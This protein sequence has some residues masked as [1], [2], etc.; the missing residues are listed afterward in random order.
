MSTSVR[1][2][3]PADPGPNAN[4]RKA[5][6]WSRGKKAT[7]FSGG[8]AGARRLPFAFGALLNRA[9]MPGG[10]EGGTGGAGWGR[11]A[12]GEW[13]A[14]TI[15]IPK[16]A[17]WADEEQARCVHVEARKKARGIR[18]NAVEQGPPLTRAFG[19]DGAPGKVIL[20][21]ATYVCVQNREIESECPPCV[22]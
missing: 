16:P 17:R 7:F 8:V 11:A 5:N 13:S 1:L 18:E 14:P 6:H 20:L 2:S 22:C 3:A 12:G 21:A 19:E 9:L 10:G 15:F 4:P